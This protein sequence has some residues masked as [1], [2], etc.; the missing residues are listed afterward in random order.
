MDE[1]QGAA[2]LVRG[3]VV[4]EG[5]GADAPR[6]GH[7]LGPVPVLDRVGQRHLQ[8]VRGEHRVRER[9][10]R[11]TDEGEGAFGV[12]CGQQPPVAGQRDAHGHVDGHRL[13]VQQRR[14]GAQF[15]RGAE[16]VPVVDGAFEHRLPQVGLQFVEHAG[17]GAGHDLSG[18]G[19]AV[20][21]R[22]GVQLGDGRLQQVEQRGVLHQRHLDDLGDAV[23]DVPGLDGAQELRVDEGDVGRVVAA[24]PVLVRAVVHA[25]LHADA[26]VDLADQGGGHAHVGHAA[27]VQA[28]RHPGHVQQ[29]AA[30]DGHDLFRPAQDAHGGHGLGDGHHL[31]EHLGVLVAR[32]GLPDGLD[33]PRREVGAEPVAVQGVHRAVDHDEA[34]GAR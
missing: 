20:G 28:G 25:G 1:H 30:A 13:A 33:A 7:P 11:G 23:G 34:A 14:V 6:Q 12:G 8:Q 2:Q 32:H 26:S 16:R 31:V 5:G 29:D 22:G 9:Q 18:G 19:A 17:D 10:A 3:D 4:D 21:E 27:P 15:Q 24:E